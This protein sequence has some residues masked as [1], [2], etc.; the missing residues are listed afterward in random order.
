MDNFM[1][2][3]HQPFLIFVDSWLTNWGSLEM[4]LKFLLD[5]LTAWRR[6]VLLYLLCLWTQW[7]TPWCSGISLS[8]SLLPMREL[9]PLK[10]MKAGIFWLIQG[11]CW[12]KNVAMWPTYSKSEDL[13][14]MRPEIYL[15]STQNQLILKPQR[16]ASQFDL[17]LTRRE[18]LISNLR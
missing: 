7:C 6:V 1:L 15:A 2:F 16:H 10:M 18:N 14:G 11:G 3:F 13:S 12:H 4:Q 5:C 17:Q 9:V 8:W